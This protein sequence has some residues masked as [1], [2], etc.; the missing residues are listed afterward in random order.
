MFT[1]HNNPEFTVDT[2][3][4]KPLKEHDGL[5]HL[6]ELGGFRDWLARLQRDAYQKDILLD[7]LKNASRKDFLKLAS[8]A[9]G[10]ADEFR[11]LVADASAA[12]GSA[13]ACDL[14][15]KRSMFGFFRRRPAGSDNDVATEWI[16][17]MQRSV[18]S[19]MNK[20]ESIGIVHIELVGKDLRDLVYEK[21]PLKA[22]VSAKN[23]PKGEKLIVKEELQGLWVTRI[24]DQLI[25]VQ[26][27]E[28]M[29]T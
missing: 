22:W 9:T 2:A 6:E 29:L 8:T 16:K 14:P 11:R 28:V 5:S 26:R 18:D 1:D 20:L 12:V 27:G 19:A 23:K 13:S 10:I 3:R 15:E 7:D 25:P 21:Q 24:E 4:A 17:A